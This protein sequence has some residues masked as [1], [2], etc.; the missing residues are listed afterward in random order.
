LET[1]KVFGVL[2]RGVNNPDGQLVPGIVK[3]EPVY[4]VL[5]AV[6][7]LRFA[8]RDELNKMVEDFLR[9]SGQPPPSPA[10]K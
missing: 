10:P 4:P 3:A 8:D 6:P 5:E 7:R 9:P 2:T 1:G